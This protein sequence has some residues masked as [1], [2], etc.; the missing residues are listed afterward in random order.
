MICTTPNKVK[1]PSMWEPALANSKK[2]VCVF[3]T[4]EHSTF[5][6]F[7]K[8]IWL[9]SPWVLSLEKQQLSDKIRLNFM[10]FRTRQNNSFH[11]LVQ[12]KTNP[13]WN[14]RQRTTQEDTCPF[15]FTVL[16][17]LKGTICVSSLL[18]LLG[19][20][21]IHPKHVQFDF[22]DPPNTYFLLYFKERE[23][24]VLTSSTISTVVFLFGPGVL[25]SFASSTAAWVAVTFWP[26]SNWTRIKKWCRLSHSNPGNRK[27]KT[28]QELAFL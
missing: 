19:P 2:S 26:V 15:K 28:K 23:K 8:W 18:S 21:M 12:N 16:I 14:P 13:V 25:N 27:F 11:D 24:R 17:R 3:F 20:H 10:V 1:S 22:F 9:I 6:E 5:K 4:T 7:Q